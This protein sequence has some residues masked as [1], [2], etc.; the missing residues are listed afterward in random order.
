MQAEHEARIAAEKQAE[1]Q[2]HTDTRRFWMSF[3]L[4]VAA[5]LVG[6]VA[7]VASILSLL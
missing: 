2:R 1:E 6:A 5:F 3:V 4:A 7:A